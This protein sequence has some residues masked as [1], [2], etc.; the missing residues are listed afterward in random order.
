VDVEE[1]DQ[2]ERERDFLLRSLDDLDAERDAGNIDDATYDRLHA[3]YTARAALV[4]RNLRDDLDLRVPDAPAVS[5]GRRW[6]WYAVVGV[7]ALAVTGLLLQSVG[8][9]EPGGSLT[10]NDASGTT[11]PST[12][13]RGQALAQAAENEPDSYP[14]RIAYARYLLN[15]DLQRAVTEYDAAAELA[16]RQPE[17][18]AYGGWIR[19][20]VATQLEAA[21]DRDLLLDAALDRLTRAIEAQP[22]YA[23]SFAFRGLAKSQVLDDPDGAVPDL[24]RFLQLT[25]PEHPQRETVLD[26]LTEA[27]ERAEPGTCEPT[28]PSTSP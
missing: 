7:F 27:C 6:L 10:G 3:D 21:D 12:V 20:L 24:Q 25:P 28:T 19:V 16:P 8:D 14:A 4:L 15:R 22:D 18:L 26:A 11:A 13:D 9:R 23:D 1:R 2:L 5:G 17:A